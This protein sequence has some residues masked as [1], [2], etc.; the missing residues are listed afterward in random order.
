VQ[1]NRQFGS[2]VNANERYGKFFTKYK[3]SPAIFE[4]GSGFENQPRPGFQRSEMPELLHIM[5]ARG[6]EDLIVN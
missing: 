3:R 6:P 5:L 2:A 4:A 1:A